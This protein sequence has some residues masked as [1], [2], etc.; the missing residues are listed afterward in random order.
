MRET[1]FIKQN[2]N[3]WI[4][5]EHALKDNKT[6]P[7]KLNRLF[8]ETT[9][10]L[11]YSRTYYSNRSVRV[12]LNG[13]AQRV[14]QLIYRTKSNRAGR[15]KA[16]WMKDLPQAMWFSRNELLLAFLLFV[17]GFG[18]GVMS[19]IYHPEFVNI[20]LGDR[21]VSMTEENI[22][23]GD[24][25]GVYK[26]GNAISMFI[27]IASN[28][29]RVALL[30]FVC[31]VFFSAGT[32]LI[33]LYNSV[34]V[35][36]FI[37][38]FVQRDLFFE[39]FYAIMLH[40]TLEL[41][42]IVL[43][44]CA[45][46]ALGRG[47]LFPGT[48]SRGQ[49]FLLSARRGIRIMMG[50]VPVLVFAAVI[51]SFATR[52]TETPDFFRGAIIV[53]SAA[54]IVGYFV[55][56]PYRLRKR[57]ILEDQEEEQLQPTKN[58]RLVLHEVKSVGRIFTELFLFYRKGISK[59]F[60]SAFLGFL[61]LVALV[62]GTGNYFY[63]IIETN[64]VYGLPPGQIIFPFPTLNDFFA[65]TEHWVLLPFAILFFFLATSTSIF[66]FEKHRLGELG[67]K[68]FIRENGMS[69]ALTAVIISLFFYLP[70][71]S[72]TT[73]AFG[74]LTPI[75]LLSLYSAIKKKIFLFSGF[76]TALQ[77]LRSNFPFMMGLHFIIF[78]VQFLFILVVGAPLLYFNLELVTMNLPADFF[79]LD[80][81]PYLLYSFAAIVGMGMV[82]PMLVYGINLFYYH[83]EEM[84]QAVS[85]KSKIAEIGIKKRAYGLEKEV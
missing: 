76:N 44:G 20:I 39:S 58:E 35:G 75:L 16:F 73:L 65:Y 66:I 83:C 78:L 74:L 36:A 31:G 37:W 27:W 12:Y 84:E 8:I 11:S 59:M 47:L 45:G 33:M 2:K 52:Y 3:K 46:L 80:D 24:P 41:S 7:E 32:V 68:K 19:S 38:F 67:Y 30:A 62:Y 25:M 50:V 81:M 72:L 55:V 34:M 26:D 60:R 13:I 85:L 82:Y 6:D 22:K 10:D 54:F 18:I 77:L 79:L 15:F 21:Y 43:A 14:F 71:W 64:L 40:G 17:F 57:G 61:A 48:Y 69:I 4:E 9:D 1:D 70:H 63:E 56:L 51:E 29:V 53:L 5:F 28:N 23:N 42:C 49:A